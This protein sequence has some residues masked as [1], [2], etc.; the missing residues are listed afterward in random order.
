MSI[1]T[2][3]GDKGQT[4]LWSGERVWKD[5]LRVEAYGTV[6]ELN[7]FL[8]EAKHFTDDNQIFAQ[9]EQIQ[10]DLFRV[11]GQLASKDK[12]YVVPMKEE[13]TERLTEWVHDYEKRIKLSGFVIPGSTLSSA[14][15]DICRT[16]TRRA[17]RIIISLKKNEDIPDHILQYM[18]RLSDLLFMMARSEEQ[19]ENKIQLKNWEK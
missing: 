8:G 11:A 5:D 15:L 7:S 19:K 3:S 12:L 16:I 18:N 17:E 13:D 9:I 6:D 10:N 1:S 14:K 2:K 4:G